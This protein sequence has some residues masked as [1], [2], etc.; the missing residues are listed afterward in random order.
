MA[1]Q[2][3]NESV[4]EETEPQKEKDMV[5]PNA[6]SFFASAWSAWGKVISKLVLGGNYYNIIIFHY[7]Y[8][9]VKMIKTIRNP[10]GR[11]LRIW[12]KLLRIR[13]P[14]LQAQRKQMKLNKK[15]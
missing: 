3:K 15:S 9:N 10:F 7:I 6:T 11:R 12:Q 2:P 1:D 14:I 13:L 8:I 5:S 4:P